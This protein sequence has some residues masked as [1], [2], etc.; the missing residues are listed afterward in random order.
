LSATMFVRLESVHRAGAAQEKRV[1]RNQHAASGTAPTQ[2][3]AWGLR[4]VLQQSSSL[5]L[6]LLLLSEQYCS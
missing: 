5:L 6:L 2:F 1:V 3:A 4:I